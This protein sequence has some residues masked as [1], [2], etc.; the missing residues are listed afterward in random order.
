M[1]GQEF[2]DRRISMGVS[3]TEIARRAGVSWRTINDLEQAS[4]IKAVKII[5]AYGLGIMPFAY[6][7]SESID[8]IESM[9]KEAIEQKIGR[10][11]KLKINIELYG[12]GEEK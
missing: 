12:K 5:E 6:G 11:C 2:K 10:K 4:D 3:Q 8:E 9:L 7:A 1:T